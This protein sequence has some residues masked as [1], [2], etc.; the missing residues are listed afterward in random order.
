MRV[1]GVVLCA[2][3]LAPVLADRA[4]AA[5]RSSTKGTLEGE[6]HQYNDYVVRMRGRGQVVTIARRSTRTCSCS[7]R[8]GTCW[9]RMTT[10]AHISLTPSPRRASPQKH[11]S[12]DVEA[13]YAVAVARIN[14]VAQPRGFVKAIDSEP[15]GLFARRC[16]VQN[17]ANS[18]ACVRCSGSCRSTTAPHGGDRS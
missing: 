9:R 11:V 12:I 8:P 14:L 18:P 16:P 1:V 17:A 4:A 2:I 3:L 13:G 7:T 6:T 15:F 5:A 10:A